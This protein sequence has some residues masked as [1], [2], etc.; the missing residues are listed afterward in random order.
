VFNIE[1]K[2]IQIMADFW[3]KIK[4][5]FIKMKGLATLG[6]G[7]YVGSAITGIF[8]IYMAS[9][10]GEENYGKISYFIAIASIAYS[11]S[12]LGAGNMIKVFVP[13]GIKIMSSISF[14]TLV[15]GAVAAIIIYLVFGNIETSLLIL[16]LG[17]F[18]L[19]T[20]YLIA[21]NMH[22]TYTKYAL[23]QKC[24][25]VIFGIIFYYLLGPHGIILGYALSFILNIKQLHLG[26]K[27]SKIDLSL[28]RSNL[29]FV[30]NNS[31]F[32][33]FRTLS[34]TTDRLVISPLFGL[35]LLGDY[36]LGM[37]FLSLL[38]MGPAVVF[39]YVLPKDAAGESNRKLKIG[40][41][42]L[43]TVFAILSIFLI[44]VFLPYVFPRFENA[45]GLVRIM[46]L[47]IIPR[48]VSMMYFSKLLANQKTIVLSIAAAIQLSVQISALITLGKMYGPIG[49][50]SSLVI[51]ESAQ[52]IFLILMNK[53]MH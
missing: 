36:E 40:I 11:V 15:L 14:I 53:K 9:L 6:F 30:I 37:Q 41:V 34:S 49:I 8:L 4:T 12:F 46:G 23:A 35:V 1:A 27:E 28:I 31:I 43:S 24:L 20:G 29:G 50:A 22:S 13:K 17:I 47:A 3:Y 33:I 52:T 38:T 32:N 48:T 18:D 25:F 5:N 19:A 21:R 39:Q 44:P 51:G 42:V 26:C 2:K 45:V 7:A 16:G 10:L